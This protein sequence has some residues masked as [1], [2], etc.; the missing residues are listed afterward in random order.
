MF[1]TSNLFFFDQQ[2]LNRGEQ[3]LLYIIIKFQVQ[4]KGTQIG[5]SP[6]KQKKIKKKV[7]SSKIIP[8]H[9]P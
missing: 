8:E 1:K 4:K 9:D 3:A 2:Y 5:K 6:F 7:S